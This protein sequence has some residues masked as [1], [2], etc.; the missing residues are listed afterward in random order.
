LEFNRPT[1]SSNIQTLAVTVPEA[2]AFFFQCFWSHNILQ[3]EHFYQA[4][5]L[6]KVHFT[7]QTASDKI[8]A[9]PMRH[10]CVYTTALGLLLVGN[11]ITLSTDWPQF[12]RASTDGVSLDPIWTNWR[13]TNTVAGQVARYYIPAKTP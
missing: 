2:G 8:S 4:K 9:I 1:V 10:L 6:I 13:F 11:S 12:R 5:H 7:G 3:L